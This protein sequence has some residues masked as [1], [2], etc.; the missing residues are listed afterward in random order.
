[1]RVVQRKQR[2]RQRRAQ[3]ALRILLSSRRTPGCHISACLRYAF[4]NASSSASFSTPRISYRHRPMTAS[5]DR[6][7]SAQERG[8]LCQHYTCNHV[9]LSLRGAAAGTYR[10]RRRPPAAAAAVERR[11]GAVRGTEKG[12]PCRMHAAQL[13]LCACCSG[14]SI[15]WR[16][17][18]PGLVHGLVVLVLPTGPGRDAHGTL[19]M[20]TAS[21]CLVLPCGSGL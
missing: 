11:A 1:M 7:R 3:R 18:A 16:R 2:Q 17:R 6:V 8:S 5:A 4:F 15:A 9:L 12:G 19:C 13:C 14:M 21:C 10:H 20:S